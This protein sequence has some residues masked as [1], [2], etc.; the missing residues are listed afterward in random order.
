MRQPIVRTVP[1]VVGLCLL[2]AA[3]AAADEQRVHSTRTIERSLP[4]ASACRLLVDNIWG[5]LRIAGHSDPLVRVE[6]V[7]TVR[8]VSAAA[9]ER[10]AREVELEIADREGVIDLFVN[11]PFRHPRDRRLR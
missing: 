3:M 11:G 6:A 1:P 4:V 7:E 10:A 5:D 2:L 9:A 8:A